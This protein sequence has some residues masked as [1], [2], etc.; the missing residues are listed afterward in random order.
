[1]VSSEER[2]GGLVCVGGGGEGIRT[3]HVHCFRLWASKTKI[4]K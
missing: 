3:P 2:V 1:M 4:K